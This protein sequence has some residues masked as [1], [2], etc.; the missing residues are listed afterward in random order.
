MFTKYLILKLDFN[1]ITVIYNSRKEVLCNNHQIIICI[2]LNSTIAYLILAHKAPAQLRNL[3][4]TLNTKDVYF[5]IHIDKKQNLDLYKKTV[6]HL[7]NVIFLSDNKRHEGTWG[8]TGIVKATID[9]IKT[10]KTLANFE[11]Y[12]L[13]SGQD[14]PLQSNEAIQ[15]YFNV[16]KEKDFI[17]IEPLNSNNNKNKYQNRILKYR[18]EISTNR[19][20]YVLI[21][22]IWKKMFYS[23]ESFINVYTLLK[24]RKIFKLMNILIN[25]NNNL[26]I[27]FF[28]G[29]QWWA[30]KDS[31]IC[32]ILNYLELHP[33]YI[34]FH[35]NTLLLDE[36][37]F[38]TIIKNIDVAE[39]RINSSL[40]YVN[41][42]RKNVSLPV[43]F[44]SSDYEELSEASKT[45][46]FARKFDEE[47]DSNIFEVVADNL[48]K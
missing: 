8:G 24:K 10:A 33:E 28:C 29:S 43:L 37:F 38:Q 16:N 1:K 42:S 21:A 35:Q 23:K 9:L 26:D 40:T 14:F 30:L 6:S 19:N 13:L 45:H 32:K 7:T 12:I 20:D 18:F 11:R 39:E 47:I 27:T 31:T 46:L 4:K 36:I 44:K 17:D 22:P 15:E 41:W 2:I 48:L 25:R 5:F 3:I 34:K